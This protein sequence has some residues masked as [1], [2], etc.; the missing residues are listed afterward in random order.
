MNE[1]IV[2]V[3]TETTGL[4]PD[5]HEVWDIAIVYPDGREWNQ[6]IEAEHLETADPTALRLNHYYSFFPSVKASTGSSSTRIASQ[7][8]L[9]RMAVAEDVAHR[10]AGMHL[11]GAVPSFDD[12]FLERFLRGYGYAPAWHYHL[13]DIETLAAGKLGMEPPYDSEQLSLALGVLPE[14]F[15]RHTALGD[16]RWAAAMYGAIFPEPEK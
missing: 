4:D 15:A 3:D 9:Q 1:N 16:A 13:V 5:R 2:F 12:R 14:R 11:V 6:L 10:L 8:P 7:L